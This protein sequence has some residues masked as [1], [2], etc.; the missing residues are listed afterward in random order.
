MTPEEQVALAVEAAGI[1]D[2]DTIA[3]MARVSV[4]ETLRVLRANPRR[5]CR[6]AQAGWRW[7]LRRTDLWSCRTACADDS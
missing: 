1:A 4:Q 6:E 7:N 5:F 2:A 3:A